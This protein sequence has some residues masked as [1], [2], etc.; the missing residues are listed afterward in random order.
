MTVWDSNQIGK[1]FITTL[2]DN[3]YLRSQIR[4]QIQKF[5]NGD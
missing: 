1:T 4:I 5:Q 2:G 3:A